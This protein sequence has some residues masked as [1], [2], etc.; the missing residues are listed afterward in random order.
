MSELSIKLTNLREERGWSK[1]YVSKKL[2]LSNM[3]TYANYEYGSREPDLEIL[4]KISD[5]YDVTT[6]Y[7]LGKTPTP[8]FTAKNERDVQNIVDDLINGLS[9]ENSLAY[10]R[11]GGEE[12][13]EEDAE[14]I[15]DALEKVARRSKILAKEKFTP[16]KYK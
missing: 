3:Q 4:K 12:I 10:L 6:D 5:L 11:N 2:G 16:N 7:L 15:K 13:D 9:N 1:T 8:Q 14:L